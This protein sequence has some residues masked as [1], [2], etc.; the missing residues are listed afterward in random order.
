MGEMAVC[1]EDEITDVVK[2]FEPKASSFALFLIVSSE[3]KGKN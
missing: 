1:T 2:A 3:E